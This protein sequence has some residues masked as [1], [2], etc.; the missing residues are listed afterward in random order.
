[1]YSSIQPIGSRL[2]ARIVSAGAVASSF[3]ITRPTLRST[4][5]QLSSTRIRRSS[6]AVASVKVLISRSHSDGSAP[7]L[8]ITERTTS[9]S[10]SGSSR[11]T[12]ASLAQYTG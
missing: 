4:C 10:A 7:S 2:V 12:S 8:R 3:V 9:S 1:M 5:S 6:E 11:S